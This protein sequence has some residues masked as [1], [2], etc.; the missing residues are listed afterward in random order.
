LVNTPVRV[1]LLNPG[2]TRTNMRAKAFPGEDPASLPAPEDIVPL[3]LE[4]ASPHC[5]LNGEIV[6]FREWR[7]IP[8]S[9]SAIQPNVIDADV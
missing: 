9:G 7:G 2:A 1:N 4:L 8:Q 5:A 3:F 6:N